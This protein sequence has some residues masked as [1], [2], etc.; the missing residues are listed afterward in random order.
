MNRRFLTCVALLGFAQPAFAGPPQDGIAK[1]AG[2]VVRA[3]GSERSIRSAMILGGVAM[4]GGGET[5]DVLSRIAMKDEMAVCSEYTALNCAHDSGPNGRASLWGF[6]LAGGRVT[7]A[8]F[9][10][11]ISIQRREVKLSKSVRF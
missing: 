5:L 2:A 9:G 7:L 4:I 11:N 3:L 10:V 6:R 8:F 1:E